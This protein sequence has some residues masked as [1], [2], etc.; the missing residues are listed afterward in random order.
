MK[1]F[2]PQIYRKTKLG[3]TLIV[4]LEE[5]VKNALIDK[6]MTDSVSVY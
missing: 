6:D 4:T 3:E 1:K 2:C 5:M